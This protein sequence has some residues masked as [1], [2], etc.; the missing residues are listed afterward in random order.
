[1]LA[2][3]LAIGLIPVLP[4]LQRQPV[5]PAGVLALFAAIA[6]G[7]VP[8]YDATH[9]E[10][11]NV[12][13]VEQNGQA[14]WI[15]SPVAR[16]P[17]A[18][19]GRAKFSITPQPGVERGYVAPRGPA[20]STLPSVRAL[21]QGREVTLDLDGAGPL[22]LFAP[23]PF[24][25]T[26]LTVNGVTVGAPPG[27]VMIGCVTPDCAHLHIVLRQERQ[28]PATLLVME[29]HGWTFPGAPAGHRAVAVGRSAD[30]GAAGNG[31]LNQTSISLAKAAFS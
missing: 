31:A 3:V 28:V 15:A 6:A 19:R 23:E 14:S 13:S 5:L 18:L 7:F 2:L 27:G 21:R 12:L 11:L 4:L 30:I 22:S 8:T 10:R 26:S 16:L 20:Q 17:G 29:R 1:M 9:P 25:M 24:A